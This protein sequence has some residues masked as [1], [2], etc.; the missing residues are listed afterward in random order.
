VGSYNPCI[1]TH[2]WSKIVPLEYWERSTLT[3]TTF[4]VDVLT[5]FFFPD[6]GFLPLLAGDIVFS[7]LHWATSGRRIKSYKILSQD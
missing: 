7:A 6:P 1:H 2:T 4:P 5:M 3:Y